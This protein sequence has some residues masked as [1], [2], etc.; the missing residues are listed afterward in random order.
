MVENEIAIKWNSV[1]PAPEEVLTLIFCTCPRKCVVETCPCIGNGLICTDACMKS[2]CGN[3]INEEIINKKN[4]KEEVEVWTW[5]G[6][7]L[8]LKFIIKSSCSCSN[9]KFEQEQDEHSE[10]ESQF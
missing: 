7:T 2:D 8:S 1:K 9:M 6:W 3:Y 10:Y 4:K 5:T